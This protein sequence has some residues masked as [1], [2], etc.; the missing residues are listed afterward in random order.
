MKIEEILG[1]NKIKKDLEISAQ[2]GTTAHSY[3][4]IGPDGIGKKLIAENF[5]RMIL[6]Q[7]HGEKK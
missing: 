1:N 3:L 4:F 2:N 5:A 7:E 6:C